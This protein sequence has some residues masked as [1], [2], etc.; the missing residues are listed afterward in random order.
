MILIFLIIVLSLL[1]QLFL[2]WWIIALV[3]FAMA[4]WK[5]ETAG[6]AFA[7]GFVAIFLLWIAM[8]LIQSVP[9]ENLLAN[10][11]GE[12]FRL[13]LGSLNWIVLLLVTGIIGG[14]VGGISAL[15]GFYSSR[16]LKSDRR[17]KGA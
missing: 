13:P 3:A 17:L 11:V 7:S 9:N 15:A 4:W 6:H 8:G 1:L 5:A 2:P 12:M 10:R 14:L 16:S